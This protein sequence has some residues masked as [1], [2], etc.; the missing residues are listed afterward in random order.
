MRISTSTNMS[1]ARQDEGQD[2]FG[3]YFTASD[4]VSDSRQ[5][6]DCRYSPGSC[7][8]C[9]SSTRGWSRCPPAAAGATAAWVTGVSAVCGRDT[10]LYCTVM[11]YHRSVGSVWLWHSGS[12]T[13]WL[14]LECLMSCPGLSRVLHLSSGPPQ[15]RPGV[16][17]MHSIDSLT[18]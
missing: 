12:G 13:H 16:C 10:V 14:T 11:Y 5:L 8:S 6:P 7:C 1:C 4:D 15:C 18:T 17:T 3:E 2:I 9:R